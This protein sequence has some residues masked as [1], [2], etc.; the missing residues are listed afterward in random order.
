[1]LR[2]VLRMYLPPVFVA[3]LC[4]LQIAP[5]FAQEQLLGMPCREVRSLDAME[6]WFWD[7]FSGFSEVQDLEQERL[8]RFVIDPGICFRIALITLDN[9]QQKNAGIRQAVS[10]LIMWT[11]DDNP[12]EE[13]A[14]RAMRQ[15]NQITGENFDTYT[16]W[17]AWWETRNNY[18]LWSEEEARLIVIISAMEAGEPIHHEAIVLATEEYW[19][20]AGRGWIRESEPVGRY[21]LGTVLIPPH[22]FNFRILKADLVD[23]DAKERGYLRAL[24]NMIVDGLLLPNLIGDSLESII[25]QI[26]TLTVESYVDRHSWVDWW[27]TNGDRLILSGSGNRLIVRQ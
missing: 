26:A 17:T 9:S 24:E 10:E 3:G 11:A 23:R 4:L 14:E 1:M 27:N 16:E 15:L 20:Y 7:A 21:V 6:Y 13:T 2:N 22:D 25:A 8:G 19:F 18:V 5:I 12:D